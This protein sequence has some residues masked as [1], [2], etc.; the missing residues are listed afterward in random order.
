MK[1]IILPLLFMWLATI[2]FGQ[3]L[4]K[5]NSY[6]DDKKYDKAK[7]ELDGFMAKTPNDTEAQ[8]LKS[9]IY[10]IIGDSAALRSMV[11]G[12]ARAEAFEAFKKA[13]ADSA[14]M[15]VK[16]MIMK[17]S[18][19]PIFSLY[20]GYYGDAAAAFNNAAASQSKEGFA[21]AMNLF[22]KSNE[23][24]KYLSESKIANIG[25]IDSMLVLNIGKAALNAGKEDEAL[26]YFSQVADNDISGTG[27]VTDENF[28]VPYQWLTMHYKEAKDEANMLKYADK[29]NKLFPK[30]DYY[31][32]TLIDYYRDKKNMVSLFKKYDD[33][34]GKNPDSLNYHFNYANDIFGYLYN[35]DEGVVVENKESLLEKLHSELDKAYNLDGENVNTNWLYSQYHYNN[36]I[37][38]RDQALKIKGTKPEDVQKKTELNDAAKA[39]W[40]KAIPYANKAITVL[41][42]RGLKTDKS[43]YKSIVNLMQNIYQ[44]I[45]DKTNLKVYQDKYDNADTKMAN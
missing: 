18:Y 24:G 4:K 1:R 31:D 28:R 17:D 37:E 42:S 43:R 3:T 36:G 41:E 6:L 10:G 30:D 26:L 19:Q 16:L 9:K 2:T 38:F 25:K 5:V 40:E 23:I 35:S 7:A 39:S 33:L 11:Q 12:D 14:N 27:G 34:V 32:F 20:A 22:I 21:D 29:G 45:G 15:K 8:Y 13:Y 44:S